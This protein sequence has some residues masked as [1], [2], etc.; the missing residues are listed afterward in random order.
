M[1]PS[2][3]HHIY[4]CYLWEYFFSC[5][6]LLQSS[7]VRTLSVSSSR[8]R[9]NIQEVLKRSDITSLT[10]RNRTAKEL[11]SMVSF[12]VAQAQVPLASDEVR[13]ESEV[14]SSCSYTNKHQFS[15]ATPAPPLLTLQSLRVAVSNWWQSRS[16]RSSSGPGSLMPVF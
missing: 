8:S 15:S 13:L 10:H 6:F 1:L 16:P 12:F 11:N 9:N 7:C 2:N 5:H 3:K 14:L 4:N